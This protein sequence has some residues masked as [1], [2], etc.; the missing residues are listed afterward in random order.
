MLKFTAR[1]DPLGQTAGLDA[2][3]GRQLGDVM[4]GG[5]TFHRWVSGDH[6][7]C[8]LLCGQPAL[9]QI[10]PQCLRAYAIER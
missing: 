7:L 6:Q 9:Q 1:W 10:Q 4:G 2:M 8:W 3:I 5:I